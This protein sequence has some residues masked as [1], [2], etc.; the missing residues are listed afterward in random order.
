[1]DTYFYIYLVIG[2]ILAT[3]TCVYETVKDKEWL[4]LSPLLFILVMFFYPLWIGTLAIFFFIMGLS[5][6][7]N[8]I[9]INRKMR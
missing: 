9:I 7:V 3:I 5:I 8:R 2:F 1:M 4:I 6:L